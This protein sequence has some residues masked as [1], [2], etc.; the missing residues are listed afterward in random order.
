MTRTGIVT[1]FAVS[2]FARGAMAQVAP[3]PV[4]GEWKVVATPEEWTGAVP[5]AVD[6]LGASNAWVIGAKPSFG[7]ARDGSAVAM[8]WDGS[9][10]A[11]EKLPD[12]G[13]L[14]IL[15]TLQSVAIAPAGDAWVVGHLRDSSGHANMPLV[16]RWSQGFWEAHQVVLL[17]SFAPR[18]ALLRDVAVVGDEEAWAV[19]EA[20]TLVDAPVG[21][22]G[23]A[24]VVSNADPFAARWDGKSWIEVPMPAAAGG[25]RIITAVAAGASNVVFAVGYDVDLVTRTS[26][27]RI[28]RW[29]GSAWSVVSLPGAKKPGALYDVVALAADDV[30]AVGAAGETGIFMHWNGSTWTSFAAAGNVIPRSVDGAR[31]NDVWAVGDKGSYHWDGT[32][33]SLAGTTDRRAVAAAGPC[34]VWAIRAGSLPFG[35]A[36]LVERLVAPA[37]APEPPPTPTSLIAIAKS[38]KDIVVQWRPGAKPSDVD[39]ALAF[40]IERCTGVADACGPFRVIQKVLGTNTFYV[41]SDL[42]PGTAFTY[43]VSAVNDAGSSKPTAPVTAVTLPAEEPAPAAVPTAAP[44]TKRTAASEPLPPRSEPL[45][46]YAAPAAPAWVVAKPMAATTI[47]VSWLPGAGAGQ[48]FVIE[49]CSGKLAACQTP[50]TVIAKVAG[51]TSYVDSGLQPATMYAYRVQAVNGAGASAFTKPASARTSAGGSTSPAPV[52]QAQTASE[53][54]AAPKPAPPATPVSLVAKPVSSSVITVAW[55][56]GDATDA[57]FV[58]ERCVG[59]PGACLTP[60][61]VIGKATGTAPSIADSGLQ[62]AT[63]YTYRVYAVNAAG[64]SGYSKPVS[65]RTPAA[66]STSPAPVPQTVSASD[67]L[68]SPKP[69][70]PAAPAAVIATPVSSSIISVAWKPGDATGTAFVIERCLGQAG[71]CVTPST[72]IARVPGTATSIL[73]SGLRPGTT[74]TYRVYALSAAG[75]SGYSKPVSA[76]TLAAGSTSPAPAPSVQSAP[77]S[78]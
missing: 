15:P 63:T 56:P 39:A 38:D 32:T 2:L 17:D 66:V 14:G 22:F 29:D 76:T 1:L 74:Y 43:R 42:K 31:S 13:A 34:D 65:A 64:Q 11:A 58:I 4:C 53:S 67:A 55:K 69:A 8:R 30:W 46:P 52:P 27:A 25:R 60:S 3:A 50:W 62:P 18:Q 49:R 40:V 36:S 59:L 16:L 41:D 68:V 21:T 73:D 57:T 6:A 72:V 28:F 51:T 75:K 20:Q 7:G 71:A 24:P 78:K 33:W 48:S 19:G 35:T 12:L 54:F 23:T 47:A 44:R 9:T 10:W 26:Y 45:P 70:P 61:V 37:P 77:D 5:T